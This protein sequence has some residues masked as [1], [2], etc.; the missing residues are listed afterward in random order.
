MVLQFPDICVNCGAMNGY[1]R[2]ELDKFIQRFTK[3]E[4]NERMA[5]TTTTRDEIAQQLAS[6]VP[7]VG[8]RKR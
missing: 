4:H 7:C 8:C 5:S 1:K 6:L 2:S 3:F